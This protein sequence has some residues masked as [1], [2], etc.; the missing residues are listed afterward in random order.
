MKIKRWYQLNFCGALFAETVTL[1]RTF[2]RMIR[3]FNCGTLLKKL[4]NAAEEKNA[5]RMSLRAER[6]M[7]RIVRRKRMWVGREDRDWWSS[8]SARKRGVRLR[9]GQRLALSTILSDI[10]HSHKTS[11]LF[12]HDIKQH[13]SLRLWLIAFLYEIRISR[14]NIYKISSLYLLAVLSSKH[15]C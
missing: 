15:I 3:M 4:K 8:C 7:K 6:S 5:M 13:Q 14:Q 11:K 9:R 10:S 2:L 12:T 1:F